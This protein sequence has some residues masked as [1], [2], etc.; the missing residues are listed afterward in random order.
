MLNASFDFFALFLVSFVDVFPGCLLHTVYYLGI[1]SAELLQ[2]VLM[3]VHGRLIQN[4]TKKFHYVVAYVCI[5]A[6]EIVCYLCLVFESL[7]VDIL[8]IFV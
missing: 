1:Y 3:E 6:Y 8:L 7:L 2:P 5:H 4:D